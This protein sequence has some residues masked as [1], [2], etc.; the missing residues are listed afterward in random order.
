MRV[1]SLDTASQLFDRRWSLDPWRK[2]FPMRSQPH[3]YRRPR[4]I[5]KVEFHTPREVLL[6][7]VFPSASDPTLL[8]LAC[9]NLANMCPGVRCLA[10]QNRDLEEAECG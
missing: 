2:N 7:V 1:A 3:V 9:L 5:W 4:C 8:S 6:R 10:G